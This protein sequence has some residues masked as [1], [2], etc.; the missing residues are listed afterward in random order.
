MEPDWVFISL[1]VGSFVAAAFNAAF[2]IGGAMIILAI[3]TIVLPVSAV[4]P[5]HSTLLM[6]STLGRISMFWR[7]IDWKIVLPFLV[8]SV[9]GTFLG[10]RV[11][12]ELPDNAIA[13]AIG[14]VML[15]AIWLPDVSWRPKLKHPWAIVGFFHSLLSTLFAYGA[16]FHSII[17]HTGLQRR[18]IV[19]TMA[20][21]FV[22]MTVFKIS[23]YALF[24]FDFLPYLV[25]IAASVV[26]S[27]L[28]T[29]VGKRMSESL[30][31]KNFRFAYRILITVTAVRLLYT[32][33]RNVLG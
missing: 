20:G 12:F 4:V 33:L 14:F 24:G 31:E 5:M 23:G 25:V 15:V 17:L 19:G 29:W 32:A 1:V 21:C 2:S 9:F 6:G 10:A 3:T 22:G 8:G 27:F 11:Y 16:L 13:I 30:P 18:Q 28:G 7:F 26:A